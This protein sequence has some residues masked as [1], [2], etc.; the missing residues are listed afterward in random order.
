MDSNVGIWRVRT[1]SLL[2]RI[3]QNFPIFSKQVQT[4]HIGWVA[5]GLST[6]VELRRPAQQPD[7]CWHKPQVQA[8]TSLAVGLS[9]GPSH[10]LDPSGATPE[11]EKI[12]QAVPQ[13]QILSGYLLHWLSPPA[14]SLSFLLRSTIVGPAHMQ[15]YILEGFSQEGINQLLLK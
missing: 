7:L 6:W 2:L 14:S 3:T 5:L 8:R 9:K 12:L 11:K 1:K 15:P 10:G 13:E 4:R